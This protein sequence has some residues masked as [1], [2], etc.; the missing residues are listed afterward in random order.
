[1]LML[2]QVRC[3][4]LLLHLQH[5]EP[6]RAADKGKIFGPTGM[7]R[8][9][10]DVVEMGGTDSADFAENPRNSI[11][12]NNLPSWLLQLPRAKPEIPY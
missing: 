11:W 10:D 12:R 4:R 5:V 7:L 3:W 1:M 8:Q 9:P 6:M 2:Q